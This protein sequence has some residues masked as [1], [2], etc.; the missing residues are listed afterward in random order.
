MSSNPVPSFRR[1]TV[2]A[3]AVATLA[4]VPVPGRAQDEAPAAF[5]YVAEWTLPRSQWQGFQEWTLKQDKPILER[6]ANEGVLLD[7]GFYETF[8]HTDGGNTH[9]VWWTTAS[10][11]DM[12]KVLAALAKAPSHPALVGAGHHDFLLRTASGGRRSGTVNGGYLYVNRQ[13]MRPGEGAAWQKMWDAYS[14]PVY[15]QL[16]A[17]G[18][19]AGYS[20][21]YED[22]HTGPPTVRYIATISTSAAGEDKIEA[23]LRASR[24]ELSE[25]E[26][27]AAGAASNSMTDSAEHRDYFARIIAAWFK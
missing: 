12:D 9:G 21:Q 4:V 15:E 11:A 5:T 18:A 26:R 16:L 2:A 1:L 6:L 17:D 20:V 3:L 25:G 22:V 19:L 14:K 13:V 10:F 24:G 7:W 27:E 8:V 23:A